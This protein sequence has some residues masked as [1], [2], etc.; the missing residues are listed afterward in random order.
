VADEGWLLGRV[1]S[2][3][4]FAGRYRSAGVL[5]LRGQARNIRGAVVKKE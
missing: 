1:R 2:Y 5:S 3:D 4:S